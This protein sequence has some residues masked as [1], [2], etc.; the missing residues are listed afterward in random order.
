MRILIFSIL[1]LSFV[2][3]SKAETVR[4]VYKPDKSISIIHPT[5]ES[6]RAN[7]T[8]AQWLDRV[9]TES[10]QGSLQGL[11]FDDIDSSQIPVN[12]DDRKYWEGEKGS[13]LTINIAKKNQDM[14]AKQGK[15]QR[16]K[17][18]LNLT[19]QDIEDLKEALR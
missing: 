14:Q 2:S 1:F 6:R 18:K 5:A 15:R 16:I 3:L 8:E 7:E 10:M 9:F 4:V 19:D 12:R 11:P 17:Q 13:P